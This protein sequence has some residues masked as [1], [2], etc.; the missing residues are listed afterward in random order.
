MATQNDGTGL[1]SG[2][3]DQIKQTASAIETDVERA[4]HKAAD[5]AQSTIQSVRDEAVSLKDQAMDQA[6]SA[7]EEGKSRAAE[8][9]AGVAHA[10][11]DA[12]A[13]LGENPNIAPVG[14]Y[15]EQAADAIERFASTLRS[16]DVDVLLDDVTT[17]IRRNP[18]I[19]AGVAVAI[20][21]ALS[22]LL[23]S[24]SGR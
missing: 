13:K 20:G 21:F 12:A 15:G 22:R 5:Y 10:A 11:R 16:K 2:M 3:G 4:A 18:A 1:G 17:A 7:A 19:A 23:R 9:L 24:D 14:K 6:R 8:A